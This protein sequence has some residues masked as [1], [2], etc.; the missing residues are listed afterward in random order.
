MATV[1]NP[2]SYQ[3]YAQEAIINNPAIGLFLDMGLG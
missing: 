2:H 1:Y 3:Q